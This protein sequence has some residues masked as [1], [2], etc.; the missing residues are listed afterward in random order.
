MIN[1]GIQGTVTVSLNERSSVCLNSVA[2]SVPYYRSSL[3]LVVGHTAAPCLSVTLH[4]KALV[5]D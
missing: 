5:S 2:E 4:A 3:S 1:K